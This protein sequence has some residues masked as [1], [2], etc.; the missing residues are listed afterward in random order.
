METIDSNDREIIRS[1]A[2]RQMELAKSEV[3]QKVINDWY[4][5]HAFGG[6]RPMIHIEMGTFYNEAVAPLMKCTGKT[7]REI[8]SRIHMMSFNRE[9]IGDDHPVADFFPIKVNAS[10]QPF[11]LEVSRTHAQAANTTSLGH[12]YT[13]HIMDLEQDFHKLNA[14]NI[15]INA[16]DVATQMDYINE[17][18]GDILPAKLIGDALYSVPTRDL[19]SIMDMETMYM[20][21]YDYPELFHKMMRQLTDDYL[22]FFNQMEQSKLLRPVA[23]CDYVAQGSWGFTK[24]LPETGNDLRSTDLWGY[25]DSQE[26]V[27]ISPAMFEEFLWPYYKEIAERIGLLSYGCCEPVHKVWYLFGTLPNLRKIS[28]SPWCDE[29]VMAEYLQGTNVIYHRKP[30]S[31]FL[32]TGTN[33]DEEAFRA[34]MNVTKSLTR[35]LTVEITQ[36][37]IY[38]INNDMDK[39]RRY[40]EIIRDV[41][42]SYI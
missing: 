5:H 7:A 37:D 32:G 36:R 42:D 14:A 13:H 41:F 4:K 6:G 34:Y 38:T 3:N 16:D 1:L 35:G 33:L 12:K 28:I 21:M 17:H 40:I 26:T 29:A 27:A 18:I 19:V 11:G 2:M 22:S 15:F 9:Y 31:T 25:M 30:E 23:G 39:V 20:A 8:E 10:M 24:E